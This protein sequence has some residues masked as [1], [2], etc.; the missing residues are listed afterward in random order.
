MHLPGFVSL[1]VHMHIV[2]TLDTGLYSKSQLCDQSIW[3]V[4]FGNI[5]LEV[6]IHFQCENMRKITVLYF[7]VGFRAFCASQPDK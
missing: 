4:Q 5:K 6:T 3:M 1:Q 7:C 2:L